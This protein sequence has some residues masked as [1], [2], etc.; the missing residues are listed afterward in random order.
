MIE[1]RKLAQF[2]KVIFHVDMDS[3]YASCELSAN[4]ELKETPFIVGADPKQGKGRGV[5]VSCNYAA[6]KFGVRS[7][8]P[9]SRA[10][11]L[12]PQARYVRPNFD[13]YE[14]V[15][16]RVMKLIRQYAN[17]V[18]QVSIDEAYLDVT[19]KIAMVLQDGVEKSESL[20]ITSLAN[21]IRT[22]VKNA[23]N[24]TCSIGAAETKIVAKIATDMHKPDGLTVVA[25]HE[26]LGFLAL[27]EV[28]KI[29]GVGKV[30]QRILSEEFGVKTISDLRGVDVVKLRERFGWNSTWL[31]NAANGVDESEVVESWDTISVSGETTFGEDEA[32]YA[33][34]RKVMFD[35][36]SD[37]HKRMLA[38]GY[39]FKNV[40]IKIRFTGFETHTR[41]RSLGAYSDSLELLKRETEKLLSEFY[42]S[43]KKVRLVGV[44]VSSLQKMEAGQTTLT[45]WE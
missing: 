33:K 17:L 34:V 32:D 12:C 18:E 2:R 15:S 27:L 4:P 6:R 11:E 13:L 38:E 5:V 26:V 42:E 23:E 29:P 20:A 40:G 24:I 37:V 43:E 3:F 19:D 10:W 45:T 14:Q 35:V 21:S 44:K 7:G 22:A 28:S 39:L 31:L 8:M 25:P 1:S 30:T 36:A 9:I 41:S 16:S